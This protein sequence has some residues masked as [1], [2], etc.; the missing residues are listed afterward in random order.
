MGR[1]YLRILF[2]DPEIEEIMNKIKA[3]C[4][5]DLFIDIEKFGRLKRSRT[6]Q[7]KDIKT[8]DLPLHIIKKKGQGVCV[9]V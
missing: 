4:A 5:K 6:I 3:I 7:D 2:R 8:V 9:S 1:Q